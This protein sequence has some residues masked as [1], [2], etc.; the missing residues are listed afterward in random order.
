M[1]LE[2]MRAGM[3][4]VA[5]KRPFFRRRRM[6]NGEELERPSG[7]ARPYSAPARPR[8]RSIAK[9]L[10]FSAALL[11]FVIL[12]VAGLV[13]STIYRRTAEAN[14]DERL[15]VYLQALVA[16]IATPGEDSGTG[17]GELGEPQ[18]ELALSGWY[19]QITR[20]DVPKPEIRSSRSL[21]AAKLP[22]LSDAGVAAS[23]GGARRGY[24]T[25]P[26]DQVLRMLE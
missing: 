21:F 8:P 26:D 23:A 5:A 14:F 15:G 7:S 1:F 11:S 2:P 20:L 24:A 13:L 25:G 16:D 3:K 10:F 6:R 22:R 4:Q 19:W 12:L 9:R 18:F 17:P